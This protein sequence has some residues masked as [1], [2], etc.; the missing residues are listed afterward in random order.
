[1]I[2][3]WLEAFIGWISSIVNFL[4]TLYVIGTVS[5][6]DFMVV[7]MIMAMLINIYVARGSA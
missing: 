6:L 7:I 1:M 4:D 5:A 2:T 3:T